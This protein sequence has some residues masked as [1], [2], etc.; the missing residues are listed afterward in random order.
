MT[1]SRADLDWWWDLAHKVEWTWASTYS[2]SAPHWY[3]IVGRTRG[4]DRDD[5]VKVAKL[6]RIYGE[7]GRFYSRVGLYLFN[8]ERTHKVWTMAD[9]VE[10]TEGINLAHTD[11]LYGPQT[12]SAA[13]LRRVNQ[14]RLSAED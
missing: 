8:A 13:D 2:D 10:D 4:M 1:F 7:P 5:F 6:I 9:N 3:L 12:F 14:L 11:R